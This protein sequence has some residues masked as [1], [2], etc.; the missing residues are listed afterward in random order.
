MKFYIADTHLGH[1]NIIKHSHRDTLY[2]L[3][4]LEQ[5]DRAIIKNWNEVVGEDDE[6]FIVGDLIYKSKSPIDY[7]KQL[8]GHK[9]LIM[10]NHDS[11]AKSPVACRY[12]DSIQDIKMITDNNRQ[13]VLFHYPMAEWPGYYR[14]SILLFG[15]IHNNDNEAAKIMRGLHNCYNVGADMPYMSMTPRTL[16]HIIKESGKQ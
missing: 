4:T 16:D 12:F 3:N 14:S 13:V 15:H 1:A 2:G 10:G 8:K 9:H 5:M 6:V 11:F 7:L